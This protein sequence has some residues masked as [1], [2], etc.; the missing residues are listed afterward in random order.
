[1]AS[2]VLHNLF[3]RF[4]SLEVM[5]LELGSAWVP[6]L[7]KGMDKSAVLCGGGPWLGGTLTDRPSDVFRQHVYVAPYPE[8]DIVGL[9]DLIGLDHV[10][11]G[12]DWPHPEGV[13]EPAGFLKY[14]DGL[15]DDQIRAIA[16]DNG[17][18]LLGLVA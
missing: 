10:L 9:V 4:P 17:A 2:L 5:T 6:S 1:M 13:V 7:L 3:G 8:D 16:R 12:S 14:L 11:F 18:R 15:D